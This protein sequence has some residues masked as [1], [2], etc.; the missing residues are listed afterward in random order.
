MPPIGHDLCASGPSRPSRGLL[1]D[2]EIFANLRLK[3]FHLHL[4]TKTLLRPILHVALSGMWNLPDLYISSTE[5]KF[6]G[7]RSKKNSG[8]SPGTYSSHSA[9]ISSRLRALTSL[10]SRVLGY[11]RKLFLQPWNLSPP[12]SSMT[13]C[14]VL[15][16]PGPAEVHSS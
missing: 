14:L 11:F 12:T 10:P 7:L 3:L 4:D 16:P 1:H 5:G 8:G 2:C 6:S 15:L 13:Y 9:R